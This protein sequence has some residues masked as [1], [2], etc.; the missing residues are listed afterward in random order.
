MFCFHI[1]LIAWGVVCLIRR[2]A[3]SH[4]PME[5]FDYFAQLCDF[6]KAADPCTDQ[7]FSFV[8]ALDTYITQRLIPLRWD[9]GLRSTFG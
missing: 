7:G 8:Q 4:Y 1:D 2:L 3:L 6:R 9:H 5:I